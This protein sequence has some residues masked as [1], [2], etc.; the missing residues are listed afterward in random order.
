MKEMAVGQLVDDTTEALQD[1]QLRVG[2]QFRYL[3]EF[4]LF[5]HHYG[6]ATTVVPEI[7]AQYVEDA[8]NRYFTRVKLRRIWLAVDRSLRTLR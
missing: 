2:V 7:F 1:R 4:R 3:S 8:Q 5:R 6:A